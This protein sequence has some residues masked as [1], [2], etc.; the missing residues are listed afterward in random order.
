M[1]EARFKER[2][3]EIDKEALKE[4]EETKELVM[5]KNKK[6]EIKAQKRRELTEGK[7]P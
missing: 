6:K 3:S 5:V 1:R 7:E 2:N 4:K